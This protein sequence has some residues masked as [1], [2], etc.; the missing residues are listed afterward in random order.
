MTFYMK[1]IGVKKLVVPQANF[2]LK[3]FLFTPS[4]KKT[5][6]GEKFLL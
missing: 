3:Y 5:A 4:K 6:A 2:F 1:Y